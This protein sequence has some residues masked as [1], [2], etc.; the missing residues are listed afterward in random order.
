[1]RIPAKELSTARVICTATELKLI[2]SSHG[3]SL[4]KLD[5]ARLKKKV[6]LARELRDK[7]RDVFEKQRREVQQA[8]KARVSDKNQRSE[9]KSGLFSNALARFEEQLAKLEAAPATPVKKSSAARA[10]PI[11]AKRVRGHRATRAH[12]KKQL[13]EMDVSPGRPKPPTAAAPAPVAATPA[14]P[15][16]KTV[17]RA[18]SKLPV[19]KVVSKKAPKG[20]LSAKSK[21][22]KSRSASSSAQ[23][24]AKKTRI[25]VSGKDSRVRG[26][27]SAAG[28]RSQARRDGKKS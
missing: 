10:T 1:M 4:E 19:K 18:A 27:V 21:G 6:T 9:E 13:K 15:T 14:S 2:E 7:W 26:H 5:A 22:V 28:K 23:A 3:L 24:A 12:T 8:Q 17:K 11:K 20:T 25:K 16:V